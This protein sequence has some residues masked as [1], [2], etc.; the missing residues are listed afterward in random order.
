MSVINFAAKNACF[1]LAAFLMYCATA[2]A[3]DVWDRAAH[4]AMGAGRGPSASSARGE[5]SLGLDF[6]MKNLRAAADRFSHRD[7]SGARGGH[8][9]PQCLAAARNAGVV[10]V[11][12]APT[13]VAIC[14]RDLGQRNWGGA[15][16]S[17]ASVPA[18]LG[19]CI[20]AVG[21]IPAACR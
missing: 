5:Y 2:E 12:A 11:L 10:C 19:G 9:S 8:L 21:N 7:S 1:C 15:V 17:C 14:S 18:A 20:V 16:K 3:G 4:S 13:T 6:S